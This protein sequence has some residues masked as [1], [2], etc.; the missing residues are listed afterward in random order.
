MKKNIVIFQL[1]WGGLNNFQKSWSSII[2]ANIKTFNNQH[3][4]EYKNY[5]TCLKKNRLISKI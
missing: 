2:I 3:I 4:I 5:L 1:A